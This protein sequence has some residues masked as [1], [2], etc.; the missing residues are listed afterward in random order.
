M[1]S[2]NADW[3]YSVGVDLTSANSQVD[4]FVSRTNSAL[5]GIGKVNLGGLG[6]DPF[7]AFAKSANTATDAITRQTGAFDL[8][9]RIAGNTVF[10]FI[11]YEVIMR[12][13]N[14]AITE[15]TNSLNQAGQVQMEQTLQ[16]LYNSTINVT[17]AFND[18]KI[19]AEQWGGNITDVQQAIGLWTKQVGDLGAATALASKSEEM[20]R[21]SGVQTMEVYRMSIAI[22]SQLGV[23]LNQLPAIYDSVAYAALRLSEPLR[24]IGVNGQEGMKDLL[25]GLAE[26]SATLG[27]VF[28]KDANAVIAVVAQQV[29]ALGESGKEAAKNLSTMFAALQG[30][31]AKRAEFEKILGVD[32]FKSTDN[33]LQSMKQ[34]V[35]ELYQA[36]ADGKLGVRPQQY[37]TL[38]TFE[39]TLEKTKD[40]YDQLNQHSGG[41]LDLVAFAEMDTYQ[42]QVDK[43]KTAI[44]A[45]TITIGNELLPTATQLVRV[46]STEV[47]P[48]M[49]HMVPV[50]LEV[51]RGAVLLGGAFLA[52]QAYSKFANIWDGFRVGALQAA[53]AE[54]ALANTEEIARAAGFQNA[55]QMQ[56]TAERLAM[57]T[58][59]DEQLAAA[60][61]LAAQSFARLG[62]DAG[63]SAD[64]LTAFDAKTVEA[65][66]AVDK[67]ALDEDVAAT[68]ATRLTTAAVTTGGV[69]RGI[70]AAA[71]S[72]LGPLAAIAA[73][74]L[75]V[76]AA[77][78]GLDNAK[79]AGLSVQ[80]GLGKQAFGNMPFMEKLRHSLSPTTWFDAAGSGF[81]VAGANMSGH[82]KYLSNEYQQQVLNNAVKDPTVGPQLRDWLGTYQSRL[83]K[84]DNVGA[85]DASKQIGQ[86]IQQY[87]NN[88]GMSRPDKTY[89]DLMAA[90][91]KSTTST[92]ALTHTLGAPDSDH[93]FSKTGSGGKVKRA[94]EQQVAAE[95]VNKTKADAMAAI[96]AARDQASAAA[97]TIKALKEQA[98]Q[99]GWTA[100]AVDQLTAAYNKE[101]Q[102]QVLGETA[103][104]VEI[105]NLEK[106]KQAIEALI[107]KHGAHID[108]QGNLSGG[109][110][111]SA[112]YAEAKAW[113]MAQEAIEK[114]TGAV[115]I[116]EAKRKLLSTQEQKDILAATGASVF[117]GLQNQGQLST[118]GTST[119]PYSFYGGETAPRG[120]SP[121]D[122]TTYKGMEQYAQSLMDYVS[123]SKT[124]LGKL[125]TATADMPIL[126]QALKN[127]V[128][129]F[130]KTGD[131]AAL[132]LAQK[133]STDL[134]G[135]RDAA[136]E[137][138]QK[139]QDL[140]Q[141]LEDTYL[142]IT[143]KNV[144]DIGQLLGLDKGSIDSMNALV[145]GYKQIDSELKKIDSI[146][147]EYGGSFANLPIQQKQM[148]EGLTQ[149]IKLQ[150]QLLPLIQQQK[151]IEGSVAYQDTVNALTKAGDSAIQSLMGKAKGPVEAFVKGL[152]GDVMKQ[153]WDNVAKNI[154]QSLFGDPAKKEAELLKQVYD[155]NKVNLQKIVDDEKANVV[156]KLQQFGK[157]WADSVDKLVQSNALNA[158]TGTSTSFGLGTNDLGLL[159]TDAFNSQ[160]LQGNV[161]SDVTTQA[162]T[163]ALNNTI[164]TPISNMA[165]D[166]A[167]IKG[168]AQD[169]GSSG[170]IA[171]VLSGGLGGASGGFGGFAQ[172]LLGGSMSSGGGGIF[173]LGL[174]LA[175]IGGAI[176]G[177]EGANTGAQGLHSAYG[178]AGGV[179]GGIAGGAGAMMMGMGAAGFA[180]G[181]IMGALAAMGPAGWAMIL[182]GAILGGAAGGLI[183]PHWGPATNYPDRSDTQHYG[184]FYS[185]WQGNTNQF[186]GTTIGPESQYA[187]SNN[188]AA[189]MLAWAQSNTN[190]PLAAQILGLGTTASGLNITNEHDGT[191]TFANGNTTSVT[192]LE[193]L[194]SQ[195]QQAVAGKANSSSG[196]L[197]PI[198]S[199]NAYGA[200]AGYS[201]LPGSIP[202]MNSSDYNQLLLTGMKSVPGVGFGTDAPPL[203]YQAPGVIPTSSNPQP[204]NRIPLGSNIVAVQVTTP[205]YL[206]SRVLAT[207]VNSVNAD[208]A[209][210]YGK[211][212]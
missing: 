9:N 90:I 108:K 45:F 164:A 135:L 56:V 6:G 136:T 37:E 60:N 14:G 163:T 199:I 123:K 151:A 158:N 4:Q 40:L 25:E 28:P 23:Q 180:S 178:A 107:A 33:M 128:E 167:K 131:P 201:A 149:Q 152:L 181:G 106:R 126:E 122:S 104:K 30:G 154:T 86:L 35:Q 146:V 48:T 53:Q 92:E 114:A 141:Q 170:G 31:G 68:A 211:A 130:K 118:I 54:I 139:M 96:S 115:G 62:S 57:V 116:Y 200:G 27:S 129:T 3:L 73:A 203:P 24:A 65:G 72:S 137:A 19:I 209:S 78:N 160:V 84:N 76:Q 52:M 192:N 16:R 132:A 18:A 110:G 189:Q 143:G 117:S 100:D 77:M 102:A 183:G 29:T 144:Q 15:V 153:W 155:Q 50:F 46:L 161:F 112:V 105:T 67:L 138:K 134:Y 142:S 177:V 133:L 51:T 80:T 91:Q 8:L 171:S 204:G 47:F 208:L 191:F 111:S 157:A 2:D 198:I 81:Q 22:A 194:S 148:I 41:S 98:A 140:N 193:N 12:A 176:G 36:Y 61:T 17:E 55:A 147:K 124:A 63:I 10:K 202:G 196:P 75:A 103:A 206:D 38:Q 210:R 1:S 121:F 188:M 95:G 172:S 127:A 99:T 26:S 87:V 168:I 34:H 184:Q 113:R 71:L 159:T 101:Q 169:G 5:S 195:W 42:A 179:L 173:G 7:G 182:G 66:L 197:A 88:Q 74:M 187:G 162:H 85:L 175:G 32:A 69:L 13:F 20:A 205:I 64:A 212:A 59:A 58:A 145:D 11:E 165:N 82:G 70:G 207:A 166:I 174:Q 97:D 21:A 43:L 83:N 125:D 156:T 190:N 185:D 119:N 49:E 44:Q 109:D 150:Q 39:K 93:V 89:A 94:T 79:D 186:N 120:E